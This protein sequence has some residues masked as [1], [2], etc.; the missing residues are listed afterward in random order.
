MGNR[1]RHVHVLVVGAYSN[2]QRTAGEI[3]SCVGINF[4]TVGLTCSNHGGTG[5]GSAG[6]SDSRTSF[7]NYD[8]NLR[9]TVSVR[10]FYIGSFRENGRGFQLGAESFRHIHESVA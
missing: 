6:L 5:T 4:Y 1:S 8:L 2:Q 10:K 9:R 7:P 3:N